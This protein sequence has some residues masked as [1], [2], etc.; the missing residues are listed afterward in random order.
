MFLNRKGRRTCPADLLC[1]GVA[2]VGHLPANTTISINPIKYPLQQLVERSH[3]FP[4]LR[5]MCPVCQLVAYMC[6]ATS[7][8]KQFGETLSPLRKNFAKFA[9]R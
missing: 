4:N 9:V 7:P 3:H 2:G 6:K 8:K 5:P 1:L